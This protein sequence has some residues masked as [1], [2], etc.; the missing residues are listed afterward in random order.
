MKKPNIRN[1]LKG[2][3]NR[4]KANRDKGH[5]LERKLAQEFR[6]LGYER[7]TTTRQSSRLL[8]SCKVDLNIPDFN[9]Q[10]KNVK[11]NMNY[12]DIFNDI[13]HELEDKYPERL[14]YI[15]AIIHRKQGNDLVVLSKRDFYKLVESYIFMRDHPIV[16]PDEG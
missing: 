6:D 2:Q 1:T 8:D 13:A 11:A 7:C 10:A 4:G 14:D 12:Q 5:R 16:T 9:I 3:N 15:T